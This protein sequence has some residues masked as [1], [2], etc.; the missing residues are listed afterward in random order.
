M[1]IVRPGAPCRAVIAGAVALVAG[2]G[3]IVGH[4]APALAQDVLA[5][6]G[7]TVHTAAGAPIANATIVVR[8]GK[9]AAV[10]RDVAVPSGATII[11]ASGKVII[12]GMIDEHSHIG[13]RP[14]DLND[15]PMIIG[16]QHRFLDALDLGDP[17]WKD[18]ASGGVTTVI[19]GP[20][21]GENV[22]G[23][24]IV[25]KTFGDDLSRRLITEKGGMKFAMGPKRNDA[26]PSTAMGVAANLRQYLIK[27]QE[28]TASW[29]KWEDGGKQGN[30]PARDLGYEAMAEV[31]AKRLRVRAHV[32][33][34]T[35]VMTLLRLKDEFGF[36]LTLHH[37]TE[38]YKVAPEIAKRGVSA[39][40]LPLGP[41]IGVTDDAMAG[42]VTLWKAGVKIA[43][44]TDH[45]V[46][47]QKWLRLCAALAIRYGLPEDEALKAVTRNVAEIARV[48]DRVGSIEVGKDA[49]FVVMNGTWYEPSTRVDLVFGDGKVIYDRSRAEVK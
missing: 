36:D 26:Y 37:S 22:S 35:D 4:A 8:G 5:V 43:L 2:A 27:T 31:L 18:A 39:V 7:A 19:T 40:V 1:R 25:I 6:R 13:A 28:Y 38:A 44:H 11:D 47:N 17:D 21:S 45:P 34:A 32:H 29:K 46:I 9:I 15:R 3:G 14:T 10:G 12:P 42:P 49:D 33:A 48:G 16:P 30:A 20:G 41:R 24:A 23:Q